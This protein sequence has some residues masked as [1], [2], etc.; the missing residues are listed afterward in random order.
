MET[1]DINEIIDVAAVF[2]KN[3]VN[4]RWFVWKNRKYEIKEVSYIWNSRAGEKDLA[5]FAVS[6]G[7]TSFE[8]SLDKNSLV[9]RLEKTSVL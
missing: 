9:W 5:C 7:A 1:V 8:L 6:D 4:P 2:K 3:S